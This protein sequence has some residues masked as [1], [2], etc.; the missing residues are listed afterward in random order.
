[1]TAPPVGSPP[2]PTTV[3]ELLD[4]AWLTAALGTRFPGVAITKVV[5]GPITERVSTNVRFTVESSSTLPA[6]LPAALCAKGYFSEAGRSTAGVGEVEARFYGELAPACAVRTLRSVYADV[7]PESRH[8]IVISTDVVAEGGRFLDALSPFTAD[9]VAASLEQYATLH[10]STWHDERWAGCVWLRPQRESFMVARGLPDIEDNFSGPNGSGV[11]LAVRDGQRLLDAY[12]ALVAVPTAAP[13]WPVVHGDA[14]IGNLFLDGDRRP[15][16]IDW[17]M[18][19]HGPWGLDVG[20]HIAS[21]LR[22]AERERTERDLLRHYLDQIRARGVE[23]PAWD[24]A[25]EEYRRGIVY[26]FFLWGITR[27]VAPAIIAEL[28]HRLGTA[29]CAHGSFAALG[30]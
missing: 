8:S 18:V 5:P 19:S 28:L 12:A 23:P 24:E 2:V 21:A 10:A 6:E 30:V 14:H 3:D 4:P 20:Y 7:D 27:Y 11:P 1:M 26:G 22:V 29:V 15:C 17:Q 13:G 25:W 16:L 9:Q